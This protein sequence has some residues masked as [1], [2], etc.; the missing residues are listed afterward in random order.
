MAGYLPSEIPGKLRDGINAGGS[1]IA[2]KRFVTGSPAS[3]AYPT[4][5]ADPIYGVT[6]KALAASG[7]FGSIGLD[8]KFIVTIG[9]GGLTAGQRVTAEPNT[10]KAIAWAPAAG[11]NASFCGIAVTGGSADDDAEI[12]VPGSGFIAQ[13]A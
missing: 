4:A 2:A 8:G 11:V 1:A 13:G 3:V 5:A 10:G 9:V 12:E 6:R 7:G